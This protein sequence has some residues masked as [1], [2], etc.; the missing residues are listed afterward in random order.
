MLDIT[1][2]E[3]FAILQQSP[4]I[5]KALNALNN[6]LSFIIKQ[7]NEVYNMITT[8]II[9]GFVLLIL[10]SFAQCFHAEH[11]RDGITKNLKIIDENNKAR[12]DKIKTDFKELDTKINNFDF[13]VLDTKV[14][15][16]DF[17]LSR[18][19][20]SSLNNKINTPKLNIDP[21]Q[22]EIYDD[23]SDKSSIQSFV[24]IENEQFRIDPKIS[25]KDF[26]QLFYKSLRTIIDGEHRSIYNYNRISDHKNVNNDMK[27]TIKSVMNR[28]PGIY[29]SA[30]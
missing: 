13:K 22:K 9:I 16:I 29:K 19:Q 3:V 2:S 11:Y 10:T 12:T 28:F 30:N 5:F 26:K 21:R 4:E 27:L 18:M 8:I 24:E 1:N 20:N 25:E 14:D 23:D 15:N 6:T 7:Q 17:K